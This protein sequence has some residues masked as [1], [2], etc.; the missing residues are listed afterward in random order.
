VSLKLKEKV[1]VTCVRS[2]LVY[3]SE[4]SAMNAEW[5]DDLSGWRGE[6]CN[7]CVVCLMRDKNKC[8]YTVTTKFPHSTLHF[9]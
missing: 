7:G 3:G 6:C 4:T 9:I 2:A 5:M 1:Y 8:N